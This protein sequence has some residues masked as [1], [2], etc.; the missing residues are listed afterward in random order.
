MLYYP[1]VMKKKLRLAV[2]YTWQPFTLGLIGILIVCFMLWFQLNSL[3][4]GLSVDE[5]RTQAQIASNT[6]T[7]RGIMSEP[8]YLPYNTLI[9]ALQKTDAA[10]ITALRSASALIGVIGVVALYVILKYWYATR[11]AILGTVLFSTSSWFLHTARLGVSDISYILI[12]VLIAAAL[13]FQKSSRRKAYLATLVVLGAGLVYIPGM[14]WL[15]GAYFIWQFPK[16]LKEIKKIQKQY[17]AIGFVLAG[18]FFMP[19]VSS[20]VRNPSST[21]K[22]LLGLP[23][24]VPAPGALLSNSRGLFT[25]VFVNGPADPSMWLPGTPI[26]S[27]F[28]IVMFV[29]GVIWLL[30]SLRLERAR[31]QLS[32]IAIASILIILGG[33]APLAI[34]I[35]F[36][37]I[38]CVAGLTYMLNEWFV[39][40]PRNPIA[41]TAGAS[42]ITVAVVMTSFYGVTR[43]YIAW[44]NS[45]DTK[46]SFQQQAVQ[47]GTIDP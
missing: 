28:S 8:F 45:P 11:M 3:V 22:Q 34:L 35:P 23:D 42:L 16:I 1:K 31:A 5:S 4:P 38:I 18:L 37:Y 43:Y 26:L 27:I 6:L 41:R 21:L 33:P 30:R 10:S 17:L 47:S 32:A 13:W 25:D 7:I 20:F 14:I 29:I 12:L 9:Y 44:P 19:L 36:I 15:L 46:N 2:L 40:F 39:V 24:T